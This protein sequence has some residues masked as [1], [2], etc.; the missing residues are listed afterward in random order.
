MRD[1]EHS[2][3]RSRQTRFDSPRR[4]AASYSWC[5]TGSYMSTFSRGSLKVTDAFQYYTLWLLF[6]SFSKAGCT[7][8]NW[9][10]QLSFS[11]SHF[12]VEN[13][14]LLECVCVRE[15]ILCQLLCSKYLFIQGISFPRSVVQ[16]NGHLQ[17]TDMPS[18]F[19]RAPY[20]SVKMRK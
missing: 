11:C 18:C 1:T 20:L 14:L 9:K 16:L 15:P 10:L 7:Q 17:E 3:Y 13:Q 2:G 12:S 6:Y 4:W 19:L 5:S 8:G